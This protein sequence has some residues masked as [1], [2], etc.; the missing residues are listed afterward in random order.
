[1]E[2]GDL[3]KKLSPALPLTTEEKELRHWLKINRAN[4]EIEGKYDTWEIAKFALMNGFSAAIVFNQ[5]SSIR[6]A[7]CGARL[8]NV[9]AQHMYK[10]DVAMEIRAELMAKLDYI[11][12]LDLSNQWAAY[13][14][15]VTEGIE[16]QEAA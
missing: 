13:T 3:F 12:E 2:T 16:F 1:M 7:M 4:F 14:Q 5:L 6:M 8:E 9:V 15:Y 10:F 11:P